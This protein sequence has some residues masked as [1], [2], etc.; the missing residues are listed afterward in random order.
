MFDSRQFIFEPDWRARPNLD[1]SIAR[2]PG[3]LAPPRPPHV[4]RPSSMVPGRVGAR[5]SVTTETPAM[6]SGNPKLPHAKRRRSRAA[7]S[8]PRARFADYPDGNP[9]TPRR[10]VS[11]TG[12]FAHRNP[13]RPA[14]PRKGRDLDTCSWSTDAQSAPPQR[15]SR[16][17]DHRADNPS[18]GR[19]MRTL[20]YKIPIQEIDNRSIQIIRP[21]RGTNLR[22]PAVSA[23]LIRA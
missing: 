4:V 18:T 7:L 8:A 19:E 2:S 3:G 17:S 10:T 11:A 5:T 12:G 20:V 23:T 13:S 14:G 15:A 16:P 9:R 22:F 1:L 6:R 21:I